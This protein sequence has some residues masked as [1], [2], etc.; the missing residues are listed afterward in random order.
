MYVV[1]FSFIRNAIIYDYPIKESILSILSIC[2]EFVIAV[3]KSDDDTLKLIESIG[4][5]KIK[6]F[7]TVWDESLREGGKV[8]AVETDKAFQAITEK[9]DWCFYIQGDEVIHEKFLPTIKKGM[10]DNL[11]LNKIDGLLFSY[12]H[13]YGSYDYKAISSGWYKNE[14]R[15]IRNNKNI[16][17]YRDAQGF[18]KDDNKKLNVVKIDTYVYHYGWVKRPSNMQ[19]KQRTF[20]KLWHSDEWVKQNVPNVDDFDY[21]GIDILEKFIGDHP[22]VMRERIETSNWKF[23]RDLSKNKITMKE[24]VKKWLLDYLKLDFNYKNYILKN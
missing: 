20:Q 4:S 3:G 18:R 13:F 22:K 17:S 24:K 21:S 1:G 6:I 16:Y 2:D 7:E 8:L 14:V 15:V 5:D 10:Q 9:A 12:C 11:H 19:A 23:D